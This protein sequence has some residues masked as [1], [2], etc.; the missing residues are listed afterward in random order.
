MASP[1]VNANEVEIIGIF[2][3]LASLFILTAFVSLDHVKIEF[4]KC[5]IFSNVFRLAVEKV[6]IFIG[7]APSFIP[8]TY[9]CGAHF[10]YLLC[11]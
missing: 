5:K 7:H 3:I 10:F 9:G 8:R 11:N 2:T 6:S 4:F 1:S